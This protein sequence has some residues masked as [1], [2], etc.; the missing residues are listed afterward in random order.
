[1]LV[2]VYMEYSV[3]TCTMVGEFISF[4]G[5]STKHSGLHFQ[6][7]PMA[8][9]TAQFPSRL[10]WN[11]KVLWNFN[12]QIFKNSLLKKFCSINW[13]FLPELHADTVEWFTYWKFNI[14]RYSGS[15]S[16]NFQT[17]QSRI[18]SSNIFYF[19]PCASTCKNRLII[20][21]I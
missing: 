11:E 17:I 1:M 21:R 7:F 19:R 9:R 13:F 8:N 6:K 10:H 16:R 15:F 18:T 5:C 14:S 3:F 2:Q 4:S 20:Y 12:T